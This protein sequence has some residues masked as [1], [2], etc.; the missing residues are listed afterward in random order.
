MFLSI[1]YFVI[2]TIDKCNTNVITNIQKSLKLTFL[3]HNTQKIHRRYT[4]ANNKYAENLYL[5]F[6]KQ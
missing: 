4:H 5:T 6:Y 3:I 1:D 2:K